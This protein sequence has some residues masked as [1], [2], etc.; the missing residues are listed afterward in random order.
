MLSTIYYYQGSLEHLQ[1]LPLATQRL[2]I[3]YAKREGL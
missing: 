1:S 3:K 2:L